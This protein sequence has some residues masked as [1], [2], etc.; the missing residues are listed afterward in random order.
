MDIVLQAEAP[1][2]RRYTSEGLRIGKSRVLLERVIHAF[3]DGATPE[4]IVQ[5]YPTATLA[6]INSVLAYYLRHQEEIKVYLAK[7]EQKAE[8]VQKRIESEQQDLADLR[9]RLLARQNTVIACTMLRQLA[10]ENFDGDI[11]RGLLLCDPN[12]D[13]I[14]I[15]EVGLTEAD[16]PLILEWAAVHN[17]M[18]LTHDRA[19]MPDFACDRIAVGQQMPC[20]VVL[21]DRYADP[22]SDRIAVVN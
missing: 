5:R 8:D 10:D 2:L 21:N 20:N 14:R 9:K 13:L 17:R 22:A 16:D 11:T 3:E 15:Q 6:D 19:T 12:I 7:R 18:V 4:A 1:P